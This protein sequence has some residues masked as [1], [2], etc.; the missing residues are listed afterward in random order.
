M[1]PNRADCINLTTFSS[2]ANF[3][4]LVKYGSSLKTN[5]L[6]LVH[7]SKEAKKCLAE[8]LRNAISK[9]N[10]TY[11]VIESFKGMMVRL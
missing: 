5:K 3:N 7:G 1:V 10:K 2:H 6:I 11:R 9:N 4:D 8:N